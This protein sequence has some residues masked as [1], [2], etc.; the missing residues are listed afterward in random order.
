VLGIGSVNTFPRQQIHAAIEELLDASFSVRSVS[1]VRES[2]G[3]SAYPLSLLGN[4]LV[5]IIPRQQR[6]VGGV[7]LYMVSVV[8]KESMG[9]ILPR[10]AS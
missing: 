2:M 1:N 5:K 8:S 10:G 7:V 4:N 3:L 9:L 6:N